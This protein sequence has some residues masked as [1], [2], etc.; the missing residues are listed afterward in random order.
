MGMQIYLATSNDFERLKEFMEIVDCEFV[1]PLSQRPGG[2]PGRISGCLA[3]VD[4]N[5]LIAES[6]DEIVGAIGFLVNWKGS[7]AY[8]SFMAVHPAHR[9]G[10]IARKLDSALVQLLFGKGSSHVNVTTWSTNPDACLMY[11]KL[12]YQVSQMVKDHR[13]P[14]VD[15]IYF[16]KAIFAQ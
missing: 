7:E 1:P 6:D 14:G 2:I 13:G 11:R 3:A 10:K 8:I 15:T 9:G 4:S 5:Y 12:G 16:R